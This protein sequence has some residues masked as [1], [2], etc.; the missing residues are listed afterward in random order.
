M[1]LHLGSANSGK[2]SRL[3]CMTGESITTL[4][5]SFLINDTSIIPYLYPLLYII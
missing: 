2:D 1:G 5:S 3:A 4:P